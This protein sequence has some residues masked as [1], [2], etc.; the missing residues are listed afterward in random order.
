MATAMGTTPL[1]LILRCD[2]GNLLG[3]VIVVLGRDRTSNG[4][5]RRKAQIAAF[6]LAEL[7]QQAAIFCRYSAVYATISSVRHW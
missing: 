5:D 4:Y 1:S 2:R 6:S 3:H 7:G